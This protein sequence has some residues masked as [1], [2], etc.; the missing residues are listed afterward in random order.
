M[1]TTLTARTQ[2]PTITFIYRDG[3]GPAYEPV[4]VRLPGQATA[5]AV[6][7]LIGLILALAS[8]A[9]GRALLVLA[10]AT[11]RP[12]AA[13][14]R[15][16]QSWWLAVTDWREWQRDLRVIWWAIRGKEI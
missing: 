8:A 5:T 16:C 10:W 1:T 12:V 4:L 7:G 2:R 14:V 11:L 15:G 6:V 3:R 9:L 13:V